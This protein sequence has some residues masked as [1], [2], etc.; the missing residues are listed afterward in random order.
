MPLT[1][2]TWN[3]NSVRLR[4]PHV[5]RLIKAA[6]PDV[7]CLQ[8]T[9]VPD[10]LFPVD[11]LAEQGYRYHALHG[12]KGYNGVAILS[13]RPL[14]AVQTRSWC[15]REDCRH[16][17]ARIA[18]AVGAVEIHNLYVPAGGDVP[19]P[20][21][22]P[23][24]AHK[25]RFLDDLAAWFGGVYGT[26]DPLILVGDLNVAP[27]ETDVWDHKKLSRV[28]THTPVEID[29]L[30]RL[31]SSLRWVDVARRFIPPEEFLFTWWSYRQGRDGSDWRSANRGRRLDHIWATA[32]LA[33]RAT[34]VEVLTDARDW[35]PPSDH[36]P[37]VAAFD[38]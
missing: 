11:A 33:D 29:R 14:E 9:K 28:V 27:L 34:G 6:D 23:K 1:V 2:C 22:N 5:E 15:E 25:L 17:S 8:E 30:A 19:D 18:T 38:V 31:Q 35:P 21:S 13:K 37:V 24:F 10:H 7:L 16:I 4:L 3:V 20:E 32:P 12:M 36:V 26:G